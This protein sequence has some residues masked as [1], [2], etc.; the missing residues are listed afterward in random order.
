MGWWCRWGGEEVPL[1]KRPISSFFRTASYCIIS[2][3]WL[4][5]K[6]MF[7]K[8]GVIISD[9]D[10]IVYTIISSFQ[11]Q[12]SLST[13]LSVKFS[14]RKLFFSPQAFERGF[15]LYCRVT[16]VSI[17]S[18][19]AWNV[20]NFRGQWCLNLFTKILPWTKAK[21]PKMLGYFQYPLSHK[22]PCYSP[23]EI[24]Q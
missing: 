16:Y 19:T 18:Y 24:L 8:L 9:E 1:D 15:E 14:L 23:T 5:F 22:M 21:A 13:P 11:E 3:I 12:L 10:Y 2:V 17:L 6:T 20:S 4:V 7:F